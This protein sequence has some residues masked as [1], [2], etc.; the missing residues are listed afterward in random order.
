MLEFSNFK[1]KSY[2]VCRNLVIFE[3]KNHTVCW[4]LVSF[5]VKLVSSDKKKRWYQGIVCLV[6]RKK[7]VWNKKVSFWYQRKTWRGCCWWRLF[8]NKFA[9][10]TKKEETNGHGTLCINKACQIPWVLVER[11]NTL[12][13]LNLTFECR[14]DAFLD[15]KQKKV[16]GNHSTVFFFSI[17]KSCFDKKVTT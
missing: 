2:P 15:K 3:R 14:T 11:K 8:P 4:N 9:Q 7:V 17:P 16:Y 13:K 12:R 6:P 1:R 10:T 5:Q